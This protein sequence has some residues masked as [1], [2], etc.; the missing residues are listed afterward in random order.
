MDEIGWFS[1]VS[2]P[3]NRF[4]MLKK[5]LSHNPW[6]ADNFQSPFI[7]TMSK[8][9]Q[10]RLLSHL[11]SIRNNLHENHHFY[12]VF[13]YLIL[14][15]IFFANTDACFVHICKQFDRVNN[16]K[17]NTGKNVLHWYIG[18]KM[19]KFFPVV[20]VFFLLFHEWL[21]S[22]RSDLWNYLCIN[23]LTF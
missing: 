20:I 9:L 7:L 10:D 1:R 15:A 6:R 17:F 13:C 4:Q 19:S 3:L 5:T 21:S 2:N 18:S 23:K 11:W 22:S 8:L 12:S 16:R 14:L